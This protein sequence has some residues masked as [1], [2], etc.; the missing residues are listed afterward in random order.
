MS[1]P[2]PTSRSNSSRTTPCAMRWPSPRRETATWRAMALA[3]LDEMHAALGE[4]E[5][6]HRQIAEQRDELRR[7]SAAQVGGED[8]G[9]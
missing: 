4:I 6:Q 9:R 5:R 8:T 7:Y 2:S 1:R 3:G